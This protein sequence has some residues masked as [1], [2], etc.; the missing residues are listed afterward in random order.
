MNLHGSD[1]FP[2]FLKAVEFMP[3]H[4]PPRWLTG[5]A[6][7]ND[8]TRITNQREQIMENDPL[9]LYA[10]ITD[11]IKEGAKA[12]IPKS[13][14]YYKLCPVPWWNEKCENIKK[15]RN[16]AQRFD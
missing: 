10:K 14:G 12:S 2:Q 8:F 5:R 13:D 6:R 11:K 16:R 3:Q 1:H 4:G 9:T 7:W 15:E